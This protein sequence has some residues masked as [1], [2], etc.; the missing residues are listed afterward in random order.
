MTELDKA[1]ERLRASKDAPR[2]STYE[3][4]CL[5]DKLQAEVD[6]LRAAERAA[7]SIQTRI[8]PKHGFA[9]LSRINGPHLAKELVEVVEIWHEANSI[10]PANSAKHRRNWLRNFNS[11][12]NR[13]YAV[14]MVAMPPE[15]EWEPE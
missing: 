9:V 13:Q 6:R 3:G 4:R 5:T 7:A 2:S 14:A 1:I 8:I 11:T 15:S 12:P 10:E